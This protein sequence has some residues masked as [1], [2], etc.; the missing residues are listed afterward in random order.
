MEKIDVFFGNYSRSLAFRKVFV[1]SFDK[2]DKAM[3]IFSL[4]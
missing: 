4:F 1:C 2:V 3:K